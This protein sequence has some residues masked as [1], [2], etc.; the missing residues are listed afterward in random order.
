MTQK[1]KVQP[2]AGRHQKVRDGAGKKLKRKD[3]GQI[4]ETG[5]F[6]LPINEYKMKTTRDEENIYNYITCNIK[7]NG[8]S[9][10]IRQ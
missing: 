7:R 10:C 3:C 4:Q 8:V 2:D 6:F 5:Y 9:R 1:K